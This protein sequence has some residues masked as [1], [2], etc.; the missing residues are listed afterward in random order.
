M[1]FGASGLYGLEYTGGQFEGKSAPPDFSVYNR[2]GLGLGA[3]AILKNAR[4][5]AGFPYLTYEV[6]GGALL[7][8]GSFQPRLGLAVGRGEVVP[9]ASLSLAFSVVTFVEFGYTLQFPLGYAPPPWMDAHFFHLD[10]HFPLR[11]MFGD[12][13]PGPDTASTSKSA[14]DQEPGDD[15]NPDVVQWAPRPIEFSFLVGERLEEPIRLQVCRDERCRTIGEYGPGQ[16]LEST[17]R[18][19]KRLYVWH[20]GYREGT[21]V[22]IYDLE[23]EEQ[24]GACEMASI[25]PPR[26]EFRIILDGY[27]FASWSAGSDADVLKI[28]SPSGEKILYTSGPSFAVSEDDR[29][30]LFF[31]TKGT[32]RASSRRITLFDLRTGERLREQKLPNHGWVE[33]LRW[34]TSQVTVTVRTG[35]QTTTRKLPLPR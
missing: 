24:L 30:A 13:E 20:R 10:I 26:A 2:S 12:E 29:F 18:E 23:E 25:A 33:N 27:I 32:P 9:A 35:E 34:N 14:D 7:G 3:Y 4:I 15:R 8:G 5:Q 22:D 11:K 19:G 1:A 31:P 21:F 28:C 6:L 17:L 16:T